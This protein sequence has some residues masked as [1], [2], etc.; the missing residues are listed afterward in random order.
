MLSVRPVNGQQD[1]FVRE[2]D[3][4]AI[5]CVISQCIHRLFYSRK[6]LT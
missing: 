6:T 1:A 3:L 4:C 2:V 5:K